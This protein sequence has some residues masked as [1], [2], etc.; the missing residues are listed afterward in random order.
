MDS[1]MCTCLEPDLLLQWAQSIVY[2]YIE[3]I[4]L[5]EDYSDLCDLTSLMVH[6]MP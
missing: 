3:S 1:C 4:T 6:Q 2:L 5:A